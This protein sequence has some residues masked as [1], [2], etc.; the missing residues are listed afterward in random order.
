MSNVVRHVVV[1]G[2]YGQHLQIPSP[3][4]CSVCETDG[5]VTR[6]RLSTES[7]ADHSTDGVSP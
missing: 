4:T 1:G 7:S 6:W 3:R 5:E 2:E